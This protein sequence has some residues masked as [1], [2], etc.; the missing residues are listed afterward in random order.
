MVVDV[1]KH[2]VF[3]LRAITTEVKCRNVEVKS[4]DIYIYTVQM[5]GKKTDNKC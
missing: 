3:L 4:T 2:L 5:K 1:N